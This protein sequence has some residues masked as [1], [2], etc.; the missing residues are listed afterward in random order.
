M[1]QNLLSDFK[2]CPELKIVTKDFRA[3]FRIRN[4]M[5]KH[6]NGLLMLQSTSQEFGGKCYDD[7]YFATI[8]VKDKQLVN[9]ILG[10]AR[11]IGEHTTGLDPYCDLPL[12]ISGV[13]R[14]G[15]LVQST[16]ESYTPVNLVSIES[17]NIAYLRVPFEELEASKGKIIQRLQTV[18]TVPV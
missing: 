11:L 5:T 3:A 9:E 12:V 6:K 8:D 17:L 15:N 10:V 1:K 16:F 2:E 18:I 4:G 7:Q 14:F 13:F